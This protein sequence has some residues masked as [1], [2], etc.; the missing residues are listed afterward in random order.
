MEFDHAGIATR[1]A[2]ELAAL[3]GDLLGASVAHRERFAEMDVVFLDLGN[4]YLELLEPHEGGTIDRYLER[5]GAG[6][7]HLAFATDDLEGALEAAREVGIELV[8]E[9]PRPGAWDHEVAFL[10]PDSTGGILVEF[11][12]RENSQ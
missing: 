2:D 11:V 8:D 3:F 6:I 4:A 1:E 10:H 5:S 7:H 9:S 12:E